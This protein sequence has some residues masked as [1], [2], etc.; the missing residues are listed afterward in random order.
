MNKIELKPVTAL[1][2]IRLKHVLMTCDILR[3]LNLDHLVDDVYEAMA[4]HKDE[5]DFNIE[6]I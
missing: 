6:K 1:K 3:A 4:D 5:V 2:D